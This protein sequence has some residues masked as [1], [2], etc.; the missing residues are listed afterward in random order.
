MARTTELAS[1]VVASASDPH[2][3]ALSTTATR[4]IPMGLR[5]G[6]NDGAVTALRQDRDRLIGRGHEVVYEEIQ[7]GGHVP[8]PGNVPSLFTFL[9]SHRL[10]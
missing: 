6:S 5:I 7:G 8:L 9:L 1:A 2:G 10:P 3:G 4:R